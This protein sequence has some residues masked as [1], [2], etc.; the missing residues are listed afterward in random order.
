ME[1]TSTIGT[2]RGFSLIEV[3]VAVSLV[4]VVISLAWILLESVRQVA[5]EIEMPI[6]NSADPFWSQLQKEIDQLLPDPVQHDMPALR[7]SPKEGLEMISLLQNEKGIPLE[8]KIHYFTDDDILMKITENGFPLN[9]RTNVVAE[10]VSTIR[11]HA[12]QDDQKIPVW[13]PEDEHPLPARVEV[14]LETVER[15]TLTR[16]FFIPASLKYEPEN[17]ESNNQ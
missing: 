8:T 1:H 4:T 11:S 14:E 17:S 16:V 2:R 6:E 9:A 5:D 7:F 12:L 13:P 15:T 3:L 10:S